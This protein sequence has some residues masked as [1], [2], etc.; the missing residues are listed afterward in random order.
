MMIWLNAHAESGTG[1]DELVTDEIEGK[2]DKH[3]D[4]GR[5]HEFLPSHNP[6]RVV[7]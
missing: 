4:K 1:A 7:L 5:D 3:A 6:K 2:W